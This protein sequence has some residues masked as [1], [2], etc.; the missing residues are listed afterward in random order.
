MRLLQTLLILAL[1]SPA[2]IAWG[3][4]HPVPGDVNSDGTADI[5]DVQCGILSALSELGSPGADTPA[6]LP[7]DL[8]GADANC[9]EQVNVTDVLF[10]IGDALGTLLSSEVDGNGDGCIDACDPTPYV[11]ICTAELVGTSVTGQATPPTWNAHLPKLVGD[12]DHWYLAHTEFTTDVNSLSASRYF[13]FFQRIS[14]M[15]VRAS[16]VRSVSP[17]LPY[18]LM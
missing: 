6:C 16:S 8:A 13:L 3:V 9:D 11:P 10:L 17:T 1:T 4:C 12:G 5:V 7:G 18:F 14:P 15:R 2:A